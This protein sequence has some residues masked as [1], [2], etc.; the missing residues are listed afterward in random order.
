MTDEDFRRLLEQA[1]TEA[2]RTVLPR[3]DRAGR[4]LYEAHARHAEFGQASH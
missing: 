3:E 2:R 4:E 1:R